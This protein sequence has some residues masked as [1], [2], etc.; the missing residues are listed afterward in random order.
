MRMTDEAARRVMR[1]NMGFA[2]IMTP[3]LAIPALLQLFVGISSYGIVVL[4]FVACMMP[5]TFLLA[6][7][8]ERVT[9]LV[10]GD[11][12][13]EYR[14]LW[15]TI[16]FDV[17]D[18]ALVATIGQ[19]ALGNGLTGATHHLVVAGAR[20]RLLLL[21]GQMW[22]TEQL[23]ALAADL[24]AHGAPVTPIPGPITPTQLRAQDRRLMPWWQAHPVALA[25]LV[26][27]IVLAV[28]TVVTVIV[29]AVILGR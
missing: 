11:G 13:Y 7:H 3:L 12:H 19:M 20:R 23:G 16:R 8:S 14:M 25:L 9:R 29:L 21:V 2:A 26:V 4:V 18:V 27:G 28:F 22:S 1:M 10:Y 5:L 17:T 6:R 24:A 15:R